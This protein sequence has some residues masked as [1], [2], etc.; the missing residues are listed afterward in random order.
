MLFSER[1][2]GT[3]TKGGFEIL[4]KLCETPFNDSLLLKI[5]SHSLT[6]IRKYSDKNLSYYFLHKT[7]KAELSPLSLETSAQSENDLFDMLKCAYSFLHDNS[8]GDPYANDPHRKFQ[9]I[10][11]S[12]LPDYGYTMKDGVIFSTPE[13]GL[14]NLVDESMPATDIPSLD[15][16]LD[17]A[18]KLFFGR[19]ATDEDKRTAIKSI[20]DLFE[21]ARNDLAKNK[22]LSGDE[23]DIFN[24]LNNFGIRHHRE[25]QKEISEPYL[26]WVY[27]ALLNTLKTFLKLK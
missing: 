4:K 18:E 14:E 25:G 7:R 26:T 1:K 3:K 12:F 6:P 20:G 21:H 23:E 16:K 24:I 9:L 19:N 10:I 27:Y 5:K 15:E 17:H 8:A 22:Q 11:N 2:T 13:K